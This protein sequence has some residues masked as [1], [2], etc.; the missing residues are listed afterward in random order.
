MILMGKMQNLKLQPKNNDS[1]RLKLQLK[2]SGKMRHTN[3]SLRQK[4]QPRKDEMR[5]TSSSNRQ[6]LGFSTPR[7][8]AKPQ[9]RGIIIWRASSS[10][11]QK[12]GFRM[13]R[14]PFTRPT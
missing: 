5:R 4:F 1:K 14:N 8:N 10:N 6:K 9:T 3:G 2:N 7:H 13:P 11:R 12:R